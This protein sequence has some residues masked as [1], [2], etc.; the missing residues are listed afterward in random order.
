M[1]PTCRNQLKKAHSYINSNHLRPQVLA[2][3]LWNHHYQIPMQ[4]EEGYQPLEVVAV[5]ME[6]RSVESL[7]HP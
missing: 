4:V 2:L 6:H 3:Y 1:Y 7:H 5:H